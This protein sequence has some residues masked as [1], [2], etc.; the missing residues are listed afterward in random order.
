MRWG[1]AKRGKVEEEKGNVWYNSTS[2]R[3]VDKE[4]VRRGRGVNLLTTMIWKRGWGKRCSY[5]CVGR[6]KLGGLG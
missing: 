1:G 5:S 3:M 6:R 4:V 2:R